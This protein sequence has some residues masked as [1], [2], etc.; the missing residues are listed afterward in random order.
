MREK[1]RASSGV[2]LQA[3]YDVLEEGVVSTPLRRY[4]I[5]VAP[6]RITLPRAAVPLLDRVRRIGEHHVELSQPVA[7]KQLRVGEC[8]AALHLEILNPMQEEIHPRD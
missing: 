4:A 6:E 7:F 3:P 1:D 8:V 2:R 5:D